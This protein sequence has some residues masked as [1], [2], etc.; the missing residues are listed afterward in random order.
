MHNGLIDITSCHPVTRCYEY[1]GCFG[2]PFKFFSRHR[3]THLAVIIHGQ[4]SEM[5]RDIVSI[6]QLMAIATPKAARRRKAC[7]KY[8]QR[9]YIFIENRN[10][11]SSDFTLH[12]RMSKPRSWQTGQMD[13]AKDREIHM[14]GAS[15][16]FRSVS[17]VSQ[18]CLM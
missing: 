16:M 2:L 12:C 7:Q 14:N 15:K 8:G 9:R 6:G 11:P 1:N 5:K 3:H 13:D 4:G 10:S 17:M 18:G